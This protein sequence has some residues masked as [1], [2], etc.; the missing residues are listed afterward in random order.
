[1]DGYR[2]SFDKLWGYANVVRFD[3]PDGCIVLVSGSPARATKPGQIALGSV[4]AAIEQFARAVAV[5]IAPRR[6]NIV[7]PG[8]VTTPMFGDPSAE[9]DAKLEMA[10]GRHLLP[11]P[12]LPEEVAQ[13][14][15]F[16]VTNRFVTG[17]TIDVDGGW[18]L[19]GR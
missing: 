14:L 16:A 19:G 1:M 10:T 4:G 2:A 17:T 15:L 12:G 7:S 5:E 18:I 11:R 8:I 3:A 9:R 13:G 6:I